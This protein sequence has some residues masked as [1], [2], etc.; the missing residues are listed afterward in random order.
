[1]T[2]AFQNTVFSPHHL[3]TS[4]TSGLVAWFDSSWPDLLLESGTEADIRRVQS[5][6]NL[7]HARSGKP[8]LGGTFQQPTSGTRPVAASFPEGRA[9]FFY[10]AGNA[11]LSDLPASDF[12][13]MH[14]GSGCTIFT[15]P[16]QYLDGISMVL[17]TTHDLSAN[18]G[19]GF[20][21][22]STGSIAVRIGD[23]TAFED[24]ETAT[25][26]TD[27]NT[28]YTFCLRHS[29]TATH[30]LALRVN[31]ANIT[32]GGFPLTSYSTITPSAGDAQ[33][34]LHIGGCPGT[35][36]FRF[37]GWLP[38]TLVFNRYLSD[39]ECAAVEAYLM[40][41]WTMQL[42]WD[43]LV[44][45]ASLYELVAF[46][47]SN[48]SAWIDRL[49]NYA[50]TEVASPTHTTSANLGG[51]NIMRLNG[52]TQYAHFHALASQFSG[53][54]TPIS[55]I[56]CH[57]LDDVL[58]TY[59]VF[60]MGLS[61]GNRQIRI[62]SDTTPDYAFIRFDG[63]TN[64]Q[65]PFGT[66]SADAT[67]IGSSFRQT[68]GSGVVSN[69]QGIVRDDNDAACETGSITL[70]QATTGCW[71]ASGAPNQLTPGDFATQLVSSRYLNVGDYMAL[72]Y[73]IAT[74]FGLL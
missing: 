10:N 67:I 11:L 70:D 60:G 42:G 9:A 43:Q 28:T 39:A 23:G 26:F 48:G 15:I 8:G 14:N 65:I 69:Y 7:A 5:V 55:I 3:T 36:N 45:V 40:G 61:S 41:K 44:S 20:F 29:A 72:Y 58:G 12:N 13:F 1:M 68:A 46:L 22:R 2:L 74:R 52:T 35:T 32:S 34:P 38:E 51:Q 18:R 66:A 49:G 50:V 33:G 62:T 21:M 4:P 30:K 63:T 37:Y 53:N 64:P 71:L 73:A 24:V 25:S 47:H 17:T 16:R 31:G 57:E 19:L 56:S 54:D 59:S 27:A 6:S